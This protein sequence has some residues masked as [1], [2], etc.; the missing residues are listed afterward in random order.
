MNFRFRHFIFSLL[1]LG[2]F[3]VSIA[4]TPKYSNEFLTIGVSAR[5]HGMANSVVAHV[6]DVHAGYWN[7]AGLTEITLPFQVAA[8]HAEWFNGIAKYDYLGIAKKLN[9][10]PEKQSTAHL[11]CQSD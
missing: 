7:P 5:A 10:N 6:S 4:Q 8:M 1:L 11:V 3:H 2:S 9:S